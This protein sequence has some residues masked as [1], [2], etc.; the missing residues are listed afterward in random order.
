MNQPQTRKDSTVD[1]L[2]GIAI[3]DPYRWLEQGESA[4]VVEW[5]REQNAYVDASLRGEAQ[6]MF[7]GELTKHFRVVYFTNPILLAGRYFY[8]ERQPNEDQSAIYYKQGLDGEPIVLI[9]PNGQREGNTIS[10]DYWLPSWNGKYLVYGVSQGG[11]EMASIHI[12]DVDKNEDLPETISQCRHAALCWTPD[13]KGFFYTRNRPPVG[14]SA[15]EEHL[16]AKLFFHALGED[17]AKDIC[18]FGEGRPKDDMMELS[19]SRD[20][21]FLAIHVTQGWTENEVYIYDT[22]DKSLRPL[23]AGIAAKFSLEFLENEVLVHTNYKA[24]RYRVLVVSLAALFTSVDTWREFVP[25]RE[26]LLEQVRITKDRVLL[27]YL[28]NACYDLATYDHHGNRVTEVSIPPLTSL[29]DISATP[30]EAEFFYG[31]ESFVFPCIDYR[32]DPVTRTALEYRVTSNPIRPRDYVVKQEWFTSKDGTRVP[33]FVFHKSSILPGAVHPTVLYAYG[34]FASNLTPSFMRAWV[35]WLERG[36]VFAVA[37]IRGGAEFGEQWH[38]NGIL[39]KKQNGFDD[40]IAAAEYLIAQ[41]YTD[42]AHL[43]IL[44]GSNG[45]L[46]VSAVAVQRP[47]LYGAVCSRVPLT[48][49]VRFPQF[50]MAMRWVHEY[51][52]PKIK[53]QL[54]TILTWSP[55][56]NVQINKTYPPILFTTGTKDTRVDPLHARKMA[57]LFQSVVTNNSALIF[58]EQEAGHGP[59]KPIVKQVELQS[60]ILS[61]FS[62]HLGL[63]LRK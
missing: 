50:G 1:V 37:N 28:V 59:G 34:G 47:E 4:E 22:Q 13:N 40:Y 58:T 32:F 57:A 11:D 33:M 21:R 61:F 18:V 8:T 53:D 10:V 7:A 46:L 23:I 2:H 9:N 41:K 42:A 38:L 51:G 55:Y 30:T 31:V 26:H 20:G 19:M 35:P 45:G 39:E 15:G 12:R 17:P 49:M 52:D 6:E 25:E 48:D 43:G 3:P 29:S 56:H 36:G 63:S 24:D 16:Y 27:S 5:T 62:Q 14:V 54:E 44:G 60:L